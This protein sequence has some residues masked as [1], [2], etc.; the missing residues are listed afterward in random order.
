MEWLTYLIGFGLSRANLG[1]SYTNPSD[2]YALDLAGAYHV[3]SNV[4]VGMHVRGSHVEGWTGDRGGPMSA[5][6][7]H[8]FYT[9][10]VAATVHLTKGRI[11]FAPWLGLHLSSGT[12]ETLYG[13][14]DPAPTPPPET[15]D[16]GPFSGVSLGILVSID[17]VQSRGHALA[18]YGEV[19]SL[20][21]LVG[22][23]DPVDTH[24]LT[25]G[26][27]FRR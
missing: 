24:A 16:V 21:P 4:A 6:T 14:Y 26:L 27:A 15:H 19:Q 7:K 23:I 11:V 1:G 9:Y 20:V 2:S 13:A 5:D 25:V 10:D 12:S 18:I 17:V 3:D 8:Q 22:Q